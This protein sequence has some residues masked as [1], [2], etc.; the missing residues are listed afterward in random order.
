MSYFV[1]FKGSFEYPDAQTAENALLIIDDEDKNPHYSEMNILSKEDFK[2]DSENATL[3]IDFSGSIPAS[4]WY[5]C[6]RVICKMSKHATKGKI[7]CS[8]EGDPDEWVKAGRGW[9]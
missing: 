8:F 4:T 7:K 9:D 2:L 6:Q 5:G 3:S 1:K